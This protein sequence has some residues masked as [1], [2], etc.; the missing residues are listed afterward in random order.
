MDADVA[1]HPVAIHAAVE[2][3]Q[4][5][6]TGTLATTVAII[7]IAWFGLMMISGRIPRRRGLQLVLGCFI[8]FGA[9][10]IG[11]SL[12]HILGSADRDVMEV[13]GPGVVVATVPP[14]TQRVPPVNYDP[15]AGAALPRRP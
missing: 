11:A 12:T 5:T 2:W 9:S 6:L 10:T 8:V 4:Q 3:L 7:A 15:Y 14:P 13:P 1:P